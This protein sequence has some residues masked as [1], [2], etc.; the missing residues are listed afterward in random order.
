[1]SK[2]VTSASGDTKAIAGT[3][4]DGQWRRR[5]Q[6]LGARP[7]VQLSPPG[8]GSAGLQTVEGGREKEK[9][10]GDNRESHRPAPAASPK[11]KRNKAPRRRPCHA[12][13]RRGRAAQGDCPGQGYLT[14]GR[15]ARHRRPPRPG[16]AQ[17]CRASSAAAAP[18]SLL[19]GGHGTA[20]G[21]ARRRGGR[22]RSWPKG[23]ARSPP[24]PSGCTQQRGGAGP[25]A[26]EAAAGGRRAETRSRGAR[27]QR[28]GFV[29]VMRKV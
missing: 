14:E 13:R 4:D 26:A 25:G 19:G 21:L 6:G 2:S 1:M 20:P 17:S 18:F 29:V 16:R 23:A 28:A 5:R 22:W 27:R 8:P 3:K 15:G 24:D 12:G 10:I 7:W 11:L 9:E